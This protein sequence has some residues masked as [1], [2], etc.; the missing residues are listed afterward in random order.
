MFTYVWVMQTVCV[1]QVV[2][3]TM[4]FPF[5]CSHLQAHHQEH[6]SRGQWC[7]SNYFAAQHGR[8]QI[9]EGSCYI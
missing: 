2:W 8:R 3:I 6:L 1:I 9:R 5:W 7:A 4:R